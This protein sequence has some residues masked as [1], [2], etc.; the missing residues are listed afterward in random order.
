MDTRS[1]TDNG[2]GIPGASDSVDQTTSAVILHLGASSETITNYTFDAGSTT[3]GIYGA[4]AGGANDT[5]TV[6][7][8]LTAESGNSNTFRNSTFTIAL[9]VGAVAVDS[10]SILFFG[11]NNSTIGI[12]GVTVNGTTSINGTGILDIYAPTTGTVALNGGV[13]FTGT[14]KGELSLNA[15]ETGTSNLKSYATVAYL[16]DTTNTGDYVTAVRTA[17]N[18]VGD[19]A[20]L[21][22]N[23]TSGTNTYKRYNSRYRQRDFCGQS[24]LVGQDG[25]QH[26]DPEWR[27]YVYRNDKD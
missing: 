3:S 18:T 4:A 2:T 27:Q 15:A 24:A 26:T 9:D 23:G 8:T 1:G 7:G 12:A 17:S 6:T 22:I 10:G 14:G 20:F 21:T 16:D 19:Q 5:L 13:T 25:R 11:G